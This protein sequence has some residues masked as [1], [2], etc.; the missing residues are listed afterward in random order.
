MVLYELGEVLQG[1]RRTGKLEGARP[2]GIP[3]FADGSM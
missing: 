2:G 3:A 1:V